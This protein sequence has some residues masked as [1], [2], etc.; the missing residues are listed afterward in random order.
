MGKFYKYA[1]YTNSEDQVNVFDWGW[2]RT[3]LQSTVQ[4]FTGQAHVKEHKAATRR[5]ELKKLA[6]SRA[7]LEPL[8]PISLGWDQGTDEAVNNNTLLFKEGLHIHLTDPDKLLNRD[9]IPKC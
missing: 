7:C 1:A 9:A 5:G 6:I 8:L 4:I 3:L 2:Y